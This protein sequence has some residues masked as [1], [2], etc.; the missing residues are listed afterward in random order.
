M[1]VEA[2]GGFGKSALLAQLVDR[3]G[4]ADRPGPRP[5]MACFFIRADG[6]R[7]TAVAFLQA[8]NAQLLDALGAQGG[9]PPGVIELRAQASEL[10]AAA[11]AR[12]TIERPLLLIV[13][14]LDEMAA[15]EIAIADLLPTA[16]GPH[17]HVV[18]SS[19][20]EPDPRGAVPPE[21]PLQRAA[22][23][24]LA[25][26]GVTAIGSLL[27]RYGLD[28][29]S[30]GRILALTRG[31]P[32]FAR[33]VCEAIAEHGA[34]ELDR[35]EHDPPDDADDYFARQLQR[36]AEAELGDVSWRLLGALVVAHGGMTEEE[37][38]E[39][40]EQPRRSLRAAL[41]P[42][43]R[44][45]I[46]PE[47]LDIFHH[48]LRGL[49]AG[50]FSAA[51]LNEL[52]T[53]FAGWCRTYGTRGWPPETPVYV[54]EHCADHYAE[55]DP[56]SAV[57]LP[58]RAWL[59]RQRDRF[60]AA[61]G[62]IR[63]VATAIELADGDA[64]ARVRLCLIGGNAVSAASTI[65]TPALR[66]LARCGGA[67]EAR[68]RADLAVSATKRAAALGAVARGTDAARA[69]LADAIEQ[70]AVAEFKFNDFVQVLFDLV[71]TAGGD[72]PLLRRLLDVA[73]SAEWE[74]ERALCLAYVAGP[75]RAAGE[76]DAAAA[77]VRATLDD[78]RAQENVDKT[79]LANLAVAAGAAGLD[80]ALS[81]IEAGAT[82]SVELGGLA[83][84]WA[85]AGDL[86][87]ARAL[88]RRIADGPAE[89]VG[90]A[91]RLLHHPGLDEE[92][93]LLGARLAAA[94][95]ELGLPERWTSNEDLRTL[96]ALG[97]GDALAALEAQVDE[98]RND[99]FAVLAE[100]YAL[101]GD[102]AGARRC[103]QA[104]DVGD[105]S[106]LAAAVV[107]V[108]AALAAR[109]HE[110][111]ARAVADLALPHA[112]AAARAEV[113]AVLLD[114]GETTAAL[115]EARRAIRIAESIDDGGEAAGALGRLAL[116]LAAAGDRA[117]AAACADTAHARVERVLP[118]ARVSRDVDPVIDA[119]LDCGR[120]DDALA[121]ADGEYPD[122]LKLAEIAAA[123]ARAGATDRALALAE[124]VLADAPA[125]Y[126]PRARVET[127][128]TLAPV[129]RDSGYEDQAERCIGLAEGTDPDGAQFYGPAL[130]R[131]LRA[132]GRD[133]AATA[134]GLAQ[135]I[136]DKPWIVAN[137]FAEAGLDTEAAAAAREALQVLDE[138]A[139][140]YWA[141]LRLPAQLA[142]LLPAAEALRVLDGLIA[143]AATIP[144]A[145][146]RASSLLTI[147]DVLHELDQARAAI[148]L[149]DAFLA[150]WLSG[151]FNV[152]E[153]ISGG[154]LTDLDPELPR[155]LV[156]WIG[157]IDGWWTG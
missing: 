13:D 97:H 14:G 114:R 57:A 55:T 89:H 102:A 121:L 125:E 47:R 35:L 139:V 33:F 20:T 79:L 48:S 144:D 148:V 84:G 81:E 45:L 122:L 140:D 61:T 53:V 10:W 18:V 44:F 50:E 24:E 138:D 88:A 143:T 4:A 21:H 22:V 123:M 41:R 116:T 86:E 83:E 36:L 62:F 39:V 6:A 101:M 129:F 91:L 60:G 110:D 46:G 152:M 31:E 11:V 157:E 147:A 115:E 29:A 117:G 112:R 142:R 64:P 66:V 12:A 93:E 156:D 69:I 105:G 68:A 109:G 95:E 37:L 65:P 135:S 75:L 1:L 17:V 151:R 5:T 119:L 150:A 87:H 70:L 106:V 30:A 8:I 77:L 58:D 74:D 19:R 118:G 76:P 63:D 100:G 141:P 113:A 120:I 56:P 108:A 3:L 16:L 92:R 43:R 132:A 52:R 133:A 7:N 85:H 15:E 27:D 130:V 40:L 154:P 153:A 145:H 107:P 98:D 131:G 124:R 104:L 73:A 127:L 80:D 71:D 134:H 155:L 26:F 28:P 111:D 38:A 49:V 149:Q 103:L 51:E 54:L 137:V 94:R 42:V 99:T 2:R 126:G 136:D 78:A 34:G 67:E 9:T 23:L 90:D 59:T 32:L 72:L 96:G 146:K 82:S 128:F 25:A